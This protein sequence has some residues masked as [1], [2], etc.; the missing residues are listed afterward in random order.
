M[1]RTLAAVAIALSAAIIVS[2]HESYEHAAAARK[3]SPEFEMIKKLS[4][5]WKGTMKDEHGKPQPA[6]T[7]FRVVS[8]GSAVEETL[9][10]GTPFEMVDMYVDQGG[11]L[12]MTHYCAAGN[13]PHM[14]LKN[15]DPKQIVLEMD[16]TPGIDM[17]KDTHMHGL[18]I[19][20]V[21]ANHIVENWT[22]FEG[23][24]AGQHAVFK[25]ARLK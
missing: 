7:E 6:T 2:A 16:A 17:A 21:D 4:G 12:A 13:Q 14:V 9:G 10:K 11:K 22:S 19:E 8:A 18:T 25:L 5:K 15:G 24:K 1:T 23:G 3:G 20:F